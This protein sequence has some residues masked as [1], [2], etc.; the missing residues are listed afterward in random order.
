M[1]E[2]DE[3]DTG[4]KRKVSHCYKIYS[5]SYLASSL[6]FSSLFRPD[7]V[8]ISDLFL[9]KPASKSASKPAK[10]PRATKKAAKADSE[11]DDDDE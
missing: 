9:Q 5:R 4:K 11:G 6:S 8:C 3:E 10:K 7:I 1:D 2:E